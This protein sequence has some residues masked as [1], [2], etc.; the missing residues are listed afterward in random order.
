M[1]KIR[2]KIP[3]EVKEVAEV[4]N[5]NNFEAYVVGGCVRDYLM[6]KTPE[7]WDL[8]TNAWP[9]KVQEVFQEE[10]Y[11][12]FYE[13]EFGTVG[14]VLPFCPERK[15]N[16]IVEITT[17]RTESAYSKRRKPGKVEWAKTIQDDLSR[18]DFTVNAIAVK[19]DNLEVE[20]PFHGR[21]DLENKTI[22]AVGNPEERFNEDALRMLR[23]VRFATTLSFKINKETVSAIKKNSELLQ[24]ISQER[25]RDELVKIIMTKRAAKGIDL[26]RGLGLL[27]YIIPELE[28]GYGV[29]QNK[30]H[31]YD[32]YQHNLLS[33]DYAAKQNFNLRV[34]MSALLHD[35]AK[36]KVKKGQG[37]KSTFYNH[38]I[39]GAQMT[40]KI[41]ER[42]KF[43]KEEA[44]KIVNL[45]RYHLFYY[46][47][48]EVSQSSVRRLVRQVG[49]E[50]MEELLE[51]RTCDRIGSG[52]P[53]AEPYKLRHLKYVIEKT[54]Q[55]PV[56]VKMLNVGGQEVM[57]ILKIKP[58]QKIGWILEILLGLVLENPENNEKKFLEKKIKELGR[59][60]EEKIMKMAL[61]SKKEANKVEMKRDEMT[62]KKYW[63]V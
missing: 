13:N 14:V 19:A 27:K 62:K 32:C 42:L 6:D 63:V 48:G 15:F 16:E 44:K 9:E 60:T 34:R 36:P 2:F 29:E 30:H 4:L 35:I 22:K 41:L 20:D 53:K 55:D 3:Q 40:E 54:S 39:V 52:V 28:Y 11:K 7:D 31:V 25:I 1:K 23:A 12:T 49:R 5:K 47:V 38:E 33:L 61:K 46:N 10:G 59:L 26:L 56:S 45:V 43:P 21:L 57:D 18:R 17:Y 51:L 37:D 50:N 8:A 24:E 58:S